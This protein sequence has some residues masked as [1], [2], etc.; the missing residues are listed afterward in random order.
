MITRKAINYLR[1]IMPMPYQEAKKILV[2]VEKE[3]FE[4]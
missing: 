3:G 1:K 2:K 4:E